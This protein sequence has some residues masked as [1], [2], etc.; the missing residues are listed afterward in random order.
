M[1]IAGRA[2]IDVLSTT[3]IILKTAAWKEE[4]TGSGEELR[5]VA[6]AALE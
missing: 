1:L 5:N 4:R 2:M 6:M 3:R